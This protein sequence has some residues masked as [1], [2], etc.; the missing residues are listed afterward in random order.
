M[1]ATQI[2]NNYIEEMG[3]KVVSI[4]DNVEIPYK[5][6]VRSLGGKTNT[7]NRELTATEF[8]RICKLFNLNPMDFLDSEETKKIKFFK[9]PELKEEL[10]NK[11]VEETE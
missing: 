4:S 3:I 2:L 9:Y 6:L 7:K 1:T 8:L 5:T 10:N 11:S